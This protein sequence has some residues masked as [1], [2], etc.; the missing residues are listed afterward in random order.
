MLRFIYVIIMNLFR[1]PYIIPKMRR[2]AGHPEHYDEEERYRLVKHV[3]RLMKLSG[4]VHTKSFGTERGNMMHW[5][6]FIPIKS[7]VLL[8]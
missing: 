5:A 7:L 2:E 4:K 8:L 3:I 6:L 1:A